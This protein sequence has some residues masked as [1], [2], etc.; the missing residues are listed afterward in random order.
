MKTNVLIML[1]F[2]AA[3]LQAQTH[4]FIY[5]VDYRRDSTSNYHTKQV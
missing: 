2:F 1:L 3:G 5:E 4:R